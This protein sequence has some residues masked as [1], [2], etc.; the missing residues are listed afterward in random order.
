MRSVSAG[1]FAI[2]QPSQVKIAFAHICRRIEC[3]AKPRDLGEVVAAYA[4]FTAN[5]AFRCRKLRFKGSTG[6]IGMNCRIAVA[7]R[8]RCDG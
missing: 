3:R 4:L 1:A 7:G 5:N 2:R 6:G 8:P